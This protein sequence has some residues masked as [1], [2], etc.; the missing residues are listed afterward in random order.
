MKSTITAD[1]RLCNG[2]GTRLVAR[3]GF[4][5][6]YLNEERCIDCEGSGQREYTQAQIDAAAAEDKA[7]RTRNL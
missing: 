5:G 3:T 7:Q 1:C 6:A 4:G 2:R